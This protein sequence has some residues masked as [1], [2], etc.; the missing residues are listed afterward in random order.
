MFDIISDFENKKVNE[1]TLNIKVLRT[2]KERG[3]ECVFGPGKPSYKLRCNQCE[4]NNTIC[5]SVNVSIDN[6]GYSYVTAD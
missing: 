4:N 3:D 6:I 2:K 5:L 1:I